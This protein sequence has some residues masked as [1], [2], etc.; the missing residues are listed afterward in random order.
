[1]LRYLPLLIALMFPQNP[2]PSVT[3]A[4]KIYSSPSFNS[5]A[6]YALNSATSTSIGPTSSLSVTT[7]DIVVAI[8]RGTNTPTATLSFGGCSGSWT[9][10]TGSTTPWTATGVGGFM[11]MGYCI[12]TSTG[13]YTCS[14]TLSITQTYRSLQ[15]LDISPGA[16][17][18]LNI[19][20]PNAGSSTSGATATTSSFSTT[21]PT[22]HVECS[23]WATTASYKLTGATI[24]GNAATIVSSDSSSPT[25]ANYETG[26][27][28][29]TAPAALTSRTGTMTL[30]TSAAWYVGDLVFSY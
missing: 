27:A 17:S 2:G 6:Y 9:Y 18:G 7:G 3:G 13:S 4:N 26:C 14:A 25:S 19:S 29:Y 30:S 8:A 11:Q 1:M 21:G 24:A 22:F 16:E 20:S 23:T 10:G 28:V 5:Y 15:C 12:A